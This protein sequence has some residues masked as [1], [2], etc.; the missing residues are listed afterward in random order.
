VLGVSIDRLT[1]KELIAYVVD[2]AAAGHR[3]LVANVNVKAMNLAHELPWFREFLGSADRVFCDGFGVL[4]AARLLGQHVRPDHRMTCP[5][6][7][8]DLA[9]RCARRGVRMYLLAGRPGVAQQTVERL[10]ALSPLLQAK[11]HHGYFDRHGPDNDR[12]LDEICAFAPGVLFV[13]FGMPLQERW[14]RHNAHRLPA[15]VILP[16]GACFDFYAGVTP[17]APRWITNMGLEWAARLLTD[18]R[19]LWRRYLLGNPQFLARVMASSWR[20]RR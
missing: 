18:P 13:G 10:E 6:L 8:R 17:R 20:R 15:C 9:L 19:R 3:R 12:V 1:A 2:E 14:I 16:I 7:L 11:S 5:D 4:L